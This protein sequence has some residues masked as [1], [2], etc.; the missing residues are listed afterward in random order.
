MLGHRISFVPEPTPQLLKIKSLEECNYKSLVETNKYF[1]F[2]CALNAPRKKN[3]EIFSQR[4]REAI[5]INV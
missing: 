2:C 5:E 1:N 4:E 3:E